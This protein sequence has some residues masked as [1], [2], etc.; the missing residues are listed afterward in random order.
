MSQ[1]ANLTKN[2]NSYQ[3]FARTYIAYHFV[4]I[5]AGNLFSKGTLV[6]GVP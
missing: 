1:F 2:F 4:Q 3:L 5:E 6:V